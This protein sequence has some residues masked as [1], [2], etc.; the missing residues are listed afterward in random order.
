MPFYGDAS[1]DDDG[2]VAH[3]MHAYEMH[4]ILAP[5]TRKMLILEQFWHQRNA[6]TRKMLTPEE[7]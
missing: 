6:D 5:G 1:V 3:D 2:M 7:C 4:A